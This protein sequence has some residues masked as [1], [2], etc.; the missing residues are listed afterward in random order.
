MSYPKIS[1]FFLILLTLIFC[2]S[3]KKTESSEQKENLNQTNEIFNNETERKETFNY[4]IDE[5]DTIIFCSGIVQEYINKHKKEIDEV[6]KY[7][8]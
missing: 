4:S 1:A 5:M 7:L 8:I 2:Q 6:S 3:S